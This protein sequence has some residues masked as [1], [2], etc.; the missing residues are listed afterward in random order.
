ML[1]IWLCGAYIQNKTRLPRRPILDPNW[2]LM[3][4]NEIVIC[5]QEEEAFLAKVLCLVILRINH[6]VNAFD[7]KI[8][9]LSFHRP[10]IH[11][12]S[13]TFLGRNLWGNR[14]FCERRC[15]PAGYRLIGAHRRKRGSR[16]NWVTVSCL[17]E[18][19]PVST[20]DCIHYSASATSRTISA[21]HSR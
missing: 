11:E 5:M 7:L 16:S 8:W 18:P 14:T 1:F 13:Y 19:L 2:S 20:F 21:V 4:V 17:W 6:S 3:F 9:F 10:H 12:L 15:V